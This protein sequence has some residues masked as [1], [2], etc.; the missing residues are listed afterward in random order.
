MYRDIS[1]KYYPKP[2]HIKEQKRTSVYGIY[3]EN[4]QLLVVMP[5]WS[6]LWEFPGGKVE[7]GESLKQALTREFIE[8]TGCMIK[9]L[10]HKP[11]KKIKAKFCEKEKNIFYDSTLYFYQI[12]SVIKTNNP[13]D[14]K[15]VK[16]LKFYKMK[17]LSEDNLHNLH[18]SVLKVI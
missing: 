13:I 9:K 18:Y 4:N 17:K 1:G 15:E 5:Q 10:Q 3:Q 2:Q 16:Q 12:I 6:N 14:K 7:K 8:E 11:L